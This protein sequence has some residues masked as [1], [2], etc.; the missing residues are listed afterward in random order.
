[1]FRAVTQSV[2]ALSTAEA[3]FYALC[4]AMSAALGLLSLL[5]DFGLEFK[6]NIGM[7][8]SA[9]IAMASRKG[10]G[11][12]KHLQCQYLWV[13]KL[14]SSR[15]VAIKKIHTDDN[16]S[17]LLTK[18][19]QAPR[20]LKLLEMLGFVFEEEGK[21]SKSKRGAKKTRLPQR[22]LRQSLRIVEV[23]RGEVVIRPFWFR[24]VLHSP[25]GRRPL[26]RQT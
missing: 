22:H 8:A 19:L 23:S 26:Q 2:I 10:L 7:D 24:S 17:D 13:Q 6:I 11:R 1:M 21:E 16:R 9:A 3:E 5:A 25:T 4:S 15:E 18:H 20:I 12:T 14:V